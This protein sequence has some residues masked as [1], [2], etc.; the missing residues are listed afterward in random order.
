M[1]L[2]DCNLLVEKQLLQVFSAS[3]WRLIRPNPIVINLVVQRMRVETYGDLRSEGYELESCAPIGYRIAIKPDK[4]TANEIQLG[5]QTSGLVILE[6]CILKKLCWI[7]AAHLQQNLLIEGA[8]GRELSLCS[9]RTKQ[10]KGRL[11]QENAFTKRKQI[12]WWYYFTPVNPSSS[13]TANYFLLAAVSV[14]Q[15]I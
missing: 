13:C 3:G 2:K 6:Q 7:N 1:G 12:L 15:A 11:S 9:R 8:E 10:R 5:L 4:R 14:A